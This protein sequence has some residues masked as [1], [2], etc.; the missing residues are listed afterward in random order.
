MD[1]DEARGSHWNSAVYTLWVKKLIDAHASKDGRLRTPPNNAHTTQKTTPSSHYYT[2]NLTIMPV[3]SLGNMDSLYPTTGDSLLPTHE[4]RDTAIRTRGG[5]LWCC[6][7]DCC[8]CLLG[9]YC[10]CMLFGRTLKRSGISSGSCYGIVVW[11]AIIILYTAGIFAISFGSLSTIEDCV[12][13]R[14]VHQ[15]VQSCPACTAED[16]SHL[17][18]E[19][20]LQV[21]GAPLA[22]VQ[23]ETSLVS[24]TC[25][26]CA[27][28]HTSDISP[29][30]TDSNSSSIGDEIGELAFAEMDEMVTLTFECQH[31]AGMYDK[32]GLAILFFYVVSGIVFGYYRERIKTALVGGSSSQLTLSSFLLHCNPLTSACAFCQEARSVDNDVTTYW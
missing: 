8:T 3:T 1:C 13:E 32:M 6:F 17:V 27:A 12:A 10:P 31:E 22:E 9:Y 14:L 5:S 18:A 30:V 25:T 21:H 4:Q 28:M 26:K 16:I 11:L 24:T 15:R 7:S 2:N 19:A 23:S 20:K 29:P